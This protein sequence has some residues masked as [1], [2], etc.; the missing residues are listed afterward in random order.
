[1]FCSFPVSDFNCNL[2]RLSFRNENFTMLYNLYNPFPNFKSY[3]IYLKTDVVID[4][5]DTN[6]NTK[7]WRLSRHD[8][9]T[10][11]FIEWL[12]ISELASRFTSLQFC[13]TV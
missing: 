4:C 3:S 1:M 8:E 7:Q 6:R 10:G 5:E 13:T 12:D 11:E 2:P 9:E